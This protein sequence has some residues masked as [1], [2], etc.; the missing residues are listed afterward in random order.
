MATKEMFWLTGHTQAGTTLLQ[1][2][3]DAHP[4]CATYPAEPY[5]YRLFPKEQ[6]GSPGDLKRRFLFN[7]RNG[8]HPSEKFANGA[9]RTAWLE[10]KNLFLTYETASRELS[11]KP[12]YEP[13]GLNEAF[14]R[15]YYFNLHEEIHAIPGIAPKQYV[16]AT[17]TAFRAAS[18][19][20][21]PKFRLGP[22]NTFKHPCRRL[23]PDSFDWFF[24][25]WPDG[26]VVFLA[27]DP[28]ARIWS[29]IA[30]KNKRS[31]HV[32]RYSNNR[33]A[34]VEIA[35]AFTQDYVATASLEKSQRILK[36]N[37]EDLVTRPEATLRCIC[38]FLKIDFNASLLRPTSMGLE[39]RVS[40]N[41]TGSRE[42]NAKSLH[43]W[44]SNLSR[45]ERA[46]IHSCMLRARARKLY[47]P[48]KYRINAI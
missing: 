34:F 42:I 37:Y 8:L 13:R 19:E 41:R 40:T 28:F 12:F 2:L 6:F 38:S 33:K 7:M 21:M 43:K 32:V 46:I 9:D 26:K 22:H 15:S 1:K 27:R 4:E 47:R 31:G 3:F 44:K 48:A 20:A 17:F 14:F 39:D 36:I 25:H 5:F 10:R 23:F 11:R 30:Q 45:T 24:R 29:H 35:K 18:A 16:E